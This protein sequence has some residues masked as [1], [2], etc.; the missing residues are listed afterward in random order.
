M[1]GGYGSKSGFSG[2]EGGRASKNW[3]L[4]GSPGQINRDGYKETHIGPDG[5]AEWERH[6]T[7]HGNPKIH[8]N[9]H[10]HII[11]WDENGNPIFG[12]K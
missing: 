10:D 11:G 3:R 6:H 2:T 9:P 12:I 1:G 5:R 7:D 4:Y 8:T